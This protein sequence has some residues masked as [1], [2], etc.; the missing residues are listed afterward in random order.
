[1]QLS[2]R[3]RAGA[4]K[5]LTHLPA[6]VVLC[7]A[8]IGPARGDGEV[9]LRGAYYKEKATRVFQ[10]MIDVDLEV[11]ETVALQGHMLVD[12]ISSASVVAFDEERFEVGGG[13]DVTVGDYRFGGF[14]R[15][16]HEMD[17]KSL[18]GGARMAVELAQKNTTLSMLLGVGADTVSNE[19]ARGI[20]GIPERGGDVRTWMGS[21]S[22]TQ[23][24][25]PTTVAGCTYDLIRA[26]G[27]LENPYRVVPRAGEEN[28]SWEQVPESR[29]RHALFA[30]LRHFL[31]R[32]RSA[33]IASYR[34]YADDWELVGHTPEL[35]LVQE[36]IPRADLHLR[37]RYHTQTGAYFFLPVYDD[38]D[39]PLATDDPKLTAFD[40]HTLGFAFDLGLDT[41][42]AG[43]RLGT[44]R[45]DILFNYVIQNNRFGN[46]V[47]LQT[48]LAIPFGN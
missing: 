1:L 33:V 44:M 46:A 30:T 39:A 22:V 12:S 4:A 5:T 48:G 21:A 42:G 40:S 28:G 19:G 32:T 14:T 41:L 17:Y 7:M 11:S 6:A 9:Q 45:L 27:F 31:P 13:G 8:W 47:V 18:F 10:P 38:P 36:L 43:G 15:Y 23:V 24:L 29:T 20:I 26:S 35:R 2:T 25:T 3:W 34:F 16:S 37:Y